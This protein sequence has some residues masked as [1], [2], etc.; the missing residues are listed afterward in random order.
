MSI[1]WIVIFLTLLVHLK[2]ADGVA[3]SEGKL[4]LGP[5]PMG[6]SYSLSK[7]E[8]KLKWNLRGLSD[9]ADGIALALREDPPYGKLTTFS[10]CLH[11]IFVFDSIL[12]FG[13]LN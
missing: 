7:E 10:F 6:K 2:N 13:S 1:N 3:R 9:I 11:V 8:D 5:L 4:K 12:S